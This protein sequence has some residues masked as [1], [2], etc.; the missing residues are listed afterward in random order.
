MQVFQMVPSK[1]IPR[2]EVCS[3]FIFEVIICVCLFRVCYKLC[4]VEKVCVGESICTDVL[5]HTHTYM[6]IHMHA[7]THTCVHTCMHTCM[8][9]HHVST[10]M[11]ARTCARAH[12]L[13]HTHTRTQVRPCTSTHT[14]T[15]IIHAHT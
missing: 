13:A 9:T 6:H 8:Y 10:C 15:H 4:Q 12:A 1:Y 7:Y 3:F 5:K 11:H 14:H 2:T